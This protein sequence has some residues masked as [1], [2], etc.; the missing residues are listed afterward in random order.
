MATSSTALEDISS[1]NLSPTEHLLLEHFVERAVE[2]DL[3]AQYFISRIH[4]DA[5]AGV[6]ASLRSFKHDWRNLV[7][8]CRDSK[9]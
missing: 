1:A 2:P 3:A 7:S 9:H 4:G 6:E 5:G 8:K